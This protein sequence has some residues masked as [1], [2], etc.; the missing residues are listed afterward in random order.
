MR[1]LSILLATIINQMIALKGLK[2]SHMI[3]MISK[4]QQKYNK[5]NI[6]PINPKQHLNRETKRIQSKRPGK[7]GQQSLNFVLSK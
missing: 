5:N 7:L 6:C 2:I 3:L 1:T 4:R